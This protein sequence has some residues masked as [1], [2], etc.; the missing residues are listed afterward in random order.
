LKYLF[1]LV[2]SF[3][4]WSGVVQAAVQSLSPDFSMVG[5]FNLQKNASGKYL[6]QIGPLEIGV[7][8]PID[9]YSSAFAIIS[10]ES[11]VAEVEEGYMKLHALPLGLQL[12]LGKMRVDFNHLNQLHSHDL[13][14]V[15]YPRYLLDYFGPEGLIK[16]GAELAYLLPFDF[17]S[18]V[19]VQWLT[20]DA[21]LSFASGH[22]LMGLKWKN[23]FEVLDG[24]GVEVGFS[25]LQGTNPSNTP[26]F[27]YQTQI[28]GLN[29]RFKYVT[30][31]ASYL[32]F[33]NEWAWSH[34]DQAGWVDTQAAFHYLGYQLNKQWQLGAGLNHSQLPDGSASYNDTFLVGNYY[35][36]EFQYYRLKYFWDDRNNAGALLSVNFILGPHPVHEF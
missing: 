23:F 24:G 7:A 20:G 15:E 2:L 29:V 5:S 36:T 32:I 31:L 21:D 6:P 26:T 16:T 22:E 30:G 8:A 14:F 12:R 1:L 9:P 28:T 35:S 27:N 10:F 25:Q 11:G 19:K 3:L 17:Y 33:N 18:E 13:P 34:R 4:L